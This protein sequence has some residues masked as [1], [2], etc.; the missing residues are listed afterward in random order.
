MLEGSQ[1]RLL[2][3]I[4]LLSV[5][6]SPGADPGFQVKGGELNKIGPREARKYL[7]YFV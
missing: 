5:Y 4:S 6:L 2:N 3:N 1:L 7:G